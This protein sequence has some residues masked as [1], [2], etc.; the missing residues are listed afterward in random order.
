[1]IL[2]CFLVTDFFSDF[3]CQ[4]CWLGRLQGLINDIV[5]AF[6]HVFALFKQAR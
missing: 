6:D 5:D 2:L 4:S 1:M 3:S